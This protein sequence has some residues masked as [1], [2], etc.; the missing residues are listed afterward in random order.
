[1]KDLNIAYCGLY[2]GACGK[3]KKGKCA[4]C[5]NNDKATW[6]SI[7]TCCIANEY[8]SCADCKIIPLSECKKYNNF[9][10]KV[11]GFVTRTERSKCISRIKEVGYEAFAAE[12]GQLKIMSIKK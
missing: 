10:A 6:C 8:T 11:I 7:R 2:C 9:F 3:L 12:M 5:Y 4:G 1:M